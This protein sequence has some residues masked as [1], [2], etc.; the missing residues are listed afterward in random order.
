MGH[1][2]SKVILPRPGTS[3][4]FFVLGVGA[5][6]N[7]NIKCFEVNKLQLSEKTNK[8]KNKSNQTKI[9]TT[10]TTTNKCQEVKRGNERGLVTKNVRVDR[11]PD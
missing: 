8:Q 6:K 4:R 2:K 10:T 11:F 5:I 9:T 7:G 1:C 3:Q